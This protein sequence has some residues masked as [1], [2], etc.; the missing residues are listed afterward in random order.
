MSRA[1]LAAQLRAY[2][3]A[4]SEEQSFRSLF[5]NLLGR[6]DAFLRSHFSPGHFTAS[7]WVVNPDFSKILLLKH[8][9]LN[10]WLQPGG[11]ADGDIDVRAVAVRELLEETGVTAR[12][13]S[14][15]FFDL[16]IHRIPARKADPEHVHFDFRYLFVASDQLPLH[17][18][19]E[20]TE[21]KWIALDELEKYNPDASMLRLRA[22]TQRPVGLPTR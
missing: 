11:H 5:L 14:N 20:S 19:H 15:Q 1:E 7:A 2:Q 8:T 9:K 12:L 3:S 17:A 4:F 18:N 6:P 10:R 16:D 13:L 21:V 22:K